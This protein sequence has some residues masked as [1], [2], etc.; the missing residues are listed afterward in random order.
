VP[1]RDLPP[2]PPDAP[3]AG[4]GPI[5]AGPAD[6]PAET[7]AADVPGVAID[8]PAADL[9]SDAQAGPNGATC[10][11]PRDCASGFCVDG[12][13]CTV[14][15]CGE[16][17]HCVSPGGTCADDLFNQV[18]DG[19]VTQF[20]CEEG[21]HCRPLT[22][23]PC[24][25][26]NHCLSWQCTAGVCAQNVLALTPELVDF[27]AVATGQEAI[28]QYVVRNN[29][30]TPSEPFQITI[31]PIDNTT[32]F[33]LVPGLSDCGTTALAPH[34]GS[35]TFSVRYQPVAGRIHDFATIELR[36]QHPASYV[37]ATRV[38]LGGSWAGDAARLMP[39]WR[40]F[41]VVSVAGGEVL[42][43]FTID[44]PVSGGDVTV[45]RIT[46]RNPGDFTIFGAVP[47]L[48]IKTGARIQVQIRFRPG[49]LGPRVA[50]L[51]ALS[52]KG[53]GAAGLYAE[54]K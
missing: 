22:G 41:G 3:V 46:G 13:C 52:S 5:E 6:A 47:P 20:A 7:L 32:A 30:A 53:W 10:S 24:R 18:V 4:E 50:R 8:A 19:C 14:A 21:R 31:L 27:G 2:P 38:S 25:D 45:L 36:V 23:Q 15:A 42:Q 37:I 1:S 35:C 11:L 43:T 29:T 40:N 33:S 44:N 16:C 54:G 28:A 12:L 39:Y 9:P 17:Q 49:A 51:E 26:F 34:V 48:P